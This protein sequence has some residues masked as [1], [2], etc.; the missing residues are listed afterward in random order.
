[1]NFKAAIII[2]NEMCDAGVV[3]SYAVGGAVAVALHLEPINTE[4]LDVFIS[5]RGNPLI[6]DLSEVFTYLKGQGFEM[7]GEYVLIAGC[8]VQI[9]AAEDGSLEHEALEESE[10]KDL[11][12]I[13]VSVFT[14]DHLAAITLKVGRAKDK[15]RLAQIVEFDA[16]DKSK[17]S[18]I[19]RRHDLLDRWMSFKKS[20]LE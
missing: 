1:M 7:E 2:L 15:I 10:V 8:P 14:L 4:D 13:P 16:L 18:E 17:F 20:N 11:D 3:E 19:L 12:G 5:V 6:L 9:L